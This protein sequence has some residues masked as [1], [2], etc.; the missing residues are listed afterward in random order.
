MTLGAKRPGTKLATFMVAVALL[1]AYPARSAELLDPAQIAVKVSEQRVANE[2]AKKKYTWKSRTQVKRGGDEVALKVELVRYTLD[3]ELQKTVIGGTPPPKEKRGLRGL[4]QKKQQAKQREW[5]ADLQKLLTA[6]A[7]PTTGKVLDF[8]E[9]ADVRPGKDRGT[10][11]IRGTSVVKPGD[12]MVMLVD[13]E[14]KKLKKVTV[15]TR[16]DN[17]LVRMEVDHAELASGLGYTARSI[18]RVPSKTIVMT[19]ENFDFRRDG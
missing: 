1:P 2:K 6:Y 8:I 10:L 5:S 9:Q 15:R 16:L 7:L 18:V 13:G 3:G 12:E 17:E 19:V 11:R 14:T 4:K